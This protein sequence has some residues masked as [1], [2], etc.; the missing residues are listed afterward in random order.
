MKDFLLA[1]GAF[2]LV[3]MSAAMWNIAMKMKGKK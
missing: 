1:V 2:S 3:S